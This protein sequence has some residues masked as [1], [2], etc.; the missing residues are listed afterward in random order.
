MGEYVSV[1]SFEALKRLREALCKF[2]DI[3]G[4]GLDESDSVLQRTRHWVKSEQAAYWK[5]EGQK[6]AEELVRAKSALAYKKMQ[7]SALGSRPSCIEEQMA[8][9]RA[10]QRVEEAERKNEN[11][12][13]W[14]I[15]LDE[16]ML[17]YQ[18]LSGGMSQ[19][20]TVDIP[21]A[22]ALLE[23]MLLA[24]EAYAG[25]GAPGMQ[26]SVAAEGD[27]I[28]RGDVNEYRAL[29]ARTPSAAV[30]ESAELVETSA[31]P[32]QIAEPP[33]WA[34]QIVQLG[35]PPAPVGSDDRIVVGRGALKSRRIYLERLGESA[36][37]HSGW[38][39]GS[40]DNAAVAG[41]EAMKAAEA[42]SIRP[43]LVPLFVLPPGWLVVLD[44][45][46]LEAV[47]DPGDRRVLPAGDAT[48]A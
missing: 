9:N 26:G 31:L 23:N 3:V 21:N 13:R 24:L 10:K 40:V 44:G 27:S 5:R 38:Y 39:I 2:S 6:R 20:R 46:A 29:R 32:A 37:G 17:T 36:G 48:K 19:S 25:T 8:V 33:A 28:R 22:L 35:Q 47:M 45:A 7:S 15:R 11:V 18:A 42:V 43:E 12:R 1:E 34:G 14:S 41:Y 4:A 30:R 16:E